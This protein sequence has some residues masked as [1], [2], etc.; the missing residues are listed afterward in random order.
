MDAAASSHKILQNDGKQVRFEK[1]R[2]IGLKSIFL[3]ID[4]MDEHLDAA[5]ASHKILQ[6]DAK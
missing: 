1:Y 2:N 3:E 4:N 6:N 5:A